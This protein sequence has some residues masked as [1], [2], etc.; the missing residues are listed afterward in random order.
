MPC[1]MVYCTGKCTYDLEPDQLEPLWFHTTLPSCRPFPFTLWNYYDYRKIEETCRKRAV[2]KYGRSNSLFGSGKRYRPSRNGLMQPMPL[3]FL[4]RTFSL[5]VVDAI[6]FLVTTPRKNKY[7]LAFAD[8]FTLWV[9]AF[10]VKRLDTVTFMNLAIDEIV[11]RYGVPKRLLS[12]RVTNFILNLAMSFY[13]PLG[14]K[15][16]FRAAYHPQ[17]QGLVERFNGTLF[18]H[19]NDPLWKRPLLPLDLALLNTRDDW[20]SSE[21]AVYRRK[22]FCLG[23]TLVESSNSNRRKPK[24]VMREKI[25]D[26]V[27]VTFE[28][29]KIVR[30]YQYFHALVAIP[31][32]P[33]GIVTVN[34]NRLKQFEDE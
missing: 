16:L 31:S 15:K 14:I 17:T 3:I 34:G 29:G 7:R 11:S 25:K 6:G 28:V 32:Y 33:D 12:D 5:V 18:G 1:K 8:Y 23:G 24:V 19:A 4:F 2:V 27:A 9:E 20:K 22:R 13:Q 30:V 21:V 26:H 10:S